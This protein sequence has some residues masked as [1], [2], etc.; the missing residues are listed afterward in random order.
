MKLLTINTHSLVEENYEE[1]LKIFIS[2]IINEKPDIIAMQEVNQSCAAEIVSPENFGIR[3]CSEGVPLRADNHAL[4][5]MK[6]L[7]DFGISYHCVCMPFKTG[8]VGYEEGPAIM[9]LAP[10]EEVDEFLISRSSSY[11]SWKTRKAL[12]I[13]S[14]GSWFY[15]IHTGWWNDESEPF[16][17]QWERI[18]AHLKDKDKV[19][20]MGDFNCRDDIRNEGYDHIKGSGWYDS[21]AAAEVKD[22]GFTAESAIDGWRE[23]KSE[24]IRIDYIWC[25]KPNDI[26]ESRVVFNGINY[27]VI[28]DHFGVMVTVNTVK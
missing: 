26:K 14:G 22:S 9:S 16:I 18:S 10:I 11:S 13:K 2:A 1:K 12:G 27:G 25:N 28:S 17:S 7:T 19:W 20:L 3:P 23:P 15:S 5:V 21:Y 6:L 4:R 24:K 8:Y